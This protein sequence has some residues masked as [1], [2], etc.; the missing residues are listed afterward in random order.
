MPGTHGS[1]N[2]A[3]YVRELTYKSRPPKKQRK[4][5]CPRM[6]LRKAVHRRI[7]HNL[8]VGQAVHVPPR[9]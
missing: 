4:A 3:G 2:K 1:L 5:L 9:R 7:E 8:P 6:R